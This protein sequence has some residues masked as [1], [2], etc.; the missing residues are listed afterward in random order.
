MLTLLLAGLTSVMAEQPQLEGLAWLG[1]CWQSTAGTR[2][3][4]EMWMPAD[5]GVMIGGGRTVVAG[6]ARAFE[7]LRIRADGEALVYTA[8]PSGQRET[9]FRSTA[10]RATGFTVENLAHDFPQR[11]VYTR[12]GDASFTA[13]VEGPG[14]NGPRGFD[15]AF[16]RVPCESAPPK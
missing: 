14:P 8:V 3:V 11:I 12:T 4:T 16:R 1:G 15:L 6:Q 5:G 13:R 9:D 2:V 10:T 7:H